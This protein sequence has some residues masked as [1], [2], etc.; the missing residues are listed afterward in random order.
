MFQTLAQAASGDL[1]PPTVVVWVIGLVIASGLGTLVVLSVTTWYRGRS[2]DVIKTVTV[3]STEWRELKNKVDDMS[4]KLEDF[5]RWRHAVRRFAIKAQTQLN[6][7]DYALVNNTLE[8]MQE[9]E[10]VHLGD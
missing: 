2:T 9:L 4:R 8:M 1:A 3:A 10:G 5:G 7:K 6:N